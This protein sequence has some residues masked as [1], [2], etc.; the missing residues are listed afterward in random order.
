V[1]KS[2]RF[3]AQPP[4]IQPAA[5][6]GVFGLSSRWVGYSAPCRRACPI[7]GLPRMDSFLT[8]HLVSLGLSRPRIRYLSSAKHA[9]VPEDWCGSGF[10]TLAE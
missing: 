10:R 7:H 2:C 8:H 6:K 4:K 1:A 3:P 9:H 5:Q